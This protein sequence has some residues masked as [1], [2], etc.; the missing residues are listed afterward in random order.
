V[1]LLPHDLEISLAVNA[2]PKERREGAGILLLE[3]TGYVKVREATNPFT[4]IVSRRRGNFYPVCFDE[5][6]TRPIL[7]AF[8]D[9]AV[10]RLKGS[11]DAQVERQLAAGS[12]RAATSL[13]SRPGM[14][15]CCRRPPTCI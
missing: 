1:H 5:E 15:T 4:C 2:L 13:P 10:L 7:P 8:A 14:R 6:G 3:S 9:D 11:A 12:S